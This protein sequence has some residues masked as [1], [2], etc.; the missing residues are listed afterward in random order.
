MSRITELLDQITGDVGRVF[1]SADSGTLHAT[2]RGRRLEL[3][4]EPCR[5]LVDGLEVSRDDVPGAGRVSRLYELAT[6]AFLQ[7]M[8]DNVPYVVGR[9]LVL[10]STWCCAVQVAEILVSDG[11]YV[12]QY[13]RRQPDPEEVTEPSDFRVVGGRLLLGSNRRSVDSVPVAAVYQALFDSFLTGE[14]L[15]QISA[16]WDEDE[17]GVIFDAAAQ[18]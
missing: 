4:R 14:D 6:G 8:V 11:G 12:T 9:R 17:D 5:L 18:N 16:D 1:W 13:L 2:W 10:G 3:L 7:G 15:T